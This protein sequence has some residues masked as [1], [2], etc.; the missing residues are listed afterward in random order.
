MDLN[1]ELEFVLCHDVAFEKSR[2]EAHELTA[3]VIKQHELTYYQLLRIRTCLALRG[4]ENLENNPEPQNP[5]RT[6]HES[7]C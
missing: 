7:H 1:G 5:Y 3:S 4:G 2:N 6:E